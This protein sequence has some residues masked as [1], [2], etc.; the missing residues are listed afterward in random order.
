MLAVARIEVAGWLVGQYQ[1][2][3]RYQRTRD[4]RAMLGSAA[5]SHQLLD[6]PVVTGTMDMTDS[7]DEADLFTKQRLDLEL[8]AIRESDYYGRLSEFFRPLR[9]ITW[10][11]ALLVAAGTA[12]LFVVLPTASPGIFEIIA[13]IGKDK[14]LDRLRKAVAYINGSA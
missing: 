14:V 13:I 8:S 5:L 6:E 9:V 4:G 11:T 3:S 1:L 7:G 10:L 12:L 2:R